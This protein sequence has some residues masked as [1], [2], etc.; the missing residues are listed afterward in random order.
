MDIFYHDYYNL[1]MRFSIIDIQNFLPTNM[2]PLIHT[3]ISTYM[4]NAYTLSYIHT[5]VYIHAC[6]HTCTLCMHMNMN[7]C[8]LRL[9]EIVRVDEWLMCH[10][11]TPVTQVRTQGLPCQFD[12]DG[13][14]EMC[15]LILEY[16]LKSN[17]CPFV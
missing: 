9:S 4:H 11:V 7:D 16:L 13:I 12:I 14:V 8:V 6:M 15:I 1:P 2:R 10:I 17:T 3:Y 5:Y